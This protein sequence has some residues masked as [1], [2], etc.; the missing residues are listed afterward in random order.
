MDCLHW[1]TKM[2]HDENVCHPFDRNKRCAREKKIVNIIA[3]SV[4]SS[5]L[6]TTLNKHKVTFF[7]SVISM[8]PP[9]QLTGKLL[10]TGTFQITVYIK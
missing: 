8:V 3:E 1:S 5:T 4:D 9:S 7:V 6:C 2:T 10:Y